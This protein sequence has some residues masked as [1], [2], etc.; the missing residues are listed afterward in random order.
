MI[1]DAEVR[2]RRRWHWLASSGESLGVRAGLDV[3]E[4]PVSEGIEQSTFFSAQ[5]RRGFALL[6]GW[7]WQLAPWRHAGVFWG[8]RPLLAGAWLWFGLGAACF[9]GSSREGF[10]GLSLGVEL[11]ATRLRLW[12]V[13]LRDGE[14]APLAVIMG[15]RR[16]SDSDD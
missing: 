7:L 4:R 11:W 10:F 1:G 16:V 12:A 8:G 2:Y 5:G 15:D 3:L 13:L 9:F 6:V 14:H